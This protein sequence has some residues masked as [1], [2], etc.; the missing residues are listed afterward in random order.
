VIV[1]VIDLL[2]Q[3]GRTVARRRNHGSQLGFAGHDIPE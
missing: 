1:E 2:A 3:R